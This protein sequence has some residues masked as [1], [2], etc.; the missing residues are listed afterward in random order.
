M[1]SFY[2]GIL[3]LKVGMYKCKPYNY[4]FS[5]G[6]LKSIFVIRQELQVYTTPSEYQTHSEKYNNLDRL[7]GLLLSFEKWR[8]VTQKPEI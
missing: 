5:K 2:I 8:T 4:L 1:G 3:I 6:N 7:L